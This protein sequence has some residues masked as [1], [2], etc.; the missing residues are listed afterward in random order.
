MEERQLCWTVF[1][2][3][4]WAPE[5]ALPKALR[6]PDAGARGQP[7]GSFPFPESRKS[8]FFSS[9]RRSPGSS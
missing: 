6:I 8:G 9:W 3:A 2:Q 1:S 7:P 4:P 5:P